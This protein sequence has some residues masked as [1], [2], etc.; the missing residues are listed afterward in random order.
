MFTFFFWIS[1]RHLRRLLKEILI[2][3]LLLFGHLDI[4]QNPMKLWDFA[5]LTMWQLQ[6]TIYWMRRF[7]TS[8]I[9]LLWLYFPRKTKFSSPL[10]QPELGIKKILIVD[11][12]VHH[13]NGTQKMFY[14]DPRVLFFSVHRYN[15][16][17]CFWLYSMYIITFI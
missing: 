2:L 4:M 6:L 10:L 13:G 7:V 3:W 15:I 14:K 5:F 17:S 9:F 12:D 8:L 11:W 16:I 1:N